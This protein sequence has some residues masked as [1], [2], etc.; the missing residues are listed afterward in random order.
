MSDVRITL[1]LSERAQEMW[2]SF[3]DSRGTWLR[4]GPTSALI[5]L[6][7]LTRDNPELDTIE[8]FEA[9]LKRGEQLKG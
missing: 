9:L 5:V 4:Q 1:V 6:T 3:I 2:A 8:G 7:Q